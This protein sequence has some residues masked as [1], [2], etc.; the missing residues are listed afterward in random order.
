MQR[1]VVIVSKEGNFW[2]GKDWIIGGINFAKKYNID[3]ARRA[4]IMSSGAMHQARIMAIDF[5][6]EFEEGA[7]I[8]IEKKR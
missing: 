5:L 7:F 2:T 8:K 3:E 6:Y 1:Q 4:I